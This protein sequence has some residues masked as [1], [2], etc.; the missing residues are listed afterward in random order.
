MMIDLDW[1]DMFILYLQSGTL[2]SD[3]VELQ[4]LEIKA[5]AYLLVGGELYRCGGPNV[6]MKCVSTTDGR[7][8][9]QEIHGGIS[10]NHASA[11]MLV[12]KAFRQGFYWP[13]AV[14]DAA[15]VV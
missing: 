11:K 1:R 4:R 3:K 7:S 5:R 14:V 9:L 8:L 12:S 13:T 6:L 10:G 2:P 15:N